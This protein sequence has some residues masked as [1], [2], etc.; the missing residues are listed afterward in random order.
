MTKQMTRF[1]SSVRTNISFAV[2]LRGLT[3]NAHAHLRRK[4][5]PWMWR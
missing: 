2:L 5:E 4:T 3:G 1:S